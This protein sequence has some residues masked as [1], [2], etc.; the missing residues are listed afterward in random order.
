MLLNP[1]LF[2]ALRT[3]HHDPTANTNEQGKAPFQA[4]HF[5]GWPVFLLTAAQEFLRRPLCCGIPCHH[6]HAPFFSFSQT[7]LSALQ[8]HCNPQIFPGL[9]VG[10]SSPPLLLYGANSPA[11]LTASRR[12]FYNF[13]FVSLLH[14]HSFLVL[15]AISTTV[16]ARGVQDFAADSLH[17]AVCERPPFPRPSAQASSQESVT[18]VREGDLVR[19]AT[20]RCVQSTTKGAPPAS[21]PPP[22]PKAPSEPTMPTNLHPEFSLHWGTALPGVMP[23]APLPP[24]ASNQPTAPA[25][26]RLEASVLGYFPRLGLPSLAPQFS[27]CC[28]RRALEATSPTGLGEQEECC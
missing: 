25:K 10:N 16:S 14:Y 4:I 9:V 23:Q 1:A 12:H 15:P 26:W 6:Q 3:V 27:F 5:T 18:S 19:K 28:R 7:F 2:A 20:Y 11:L 24:T 22:I 13:W 21:S 8:T 17:V